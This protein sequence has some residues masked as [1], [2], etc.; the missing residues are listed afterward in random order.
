MVRKIDALADRAEFLR[1][2]LLEWG[3]EHS[4]RFP[5]RETTDPFQILVSEILLQ[6]TFAAKVAPVFVNLVSLCPTVQ[7]MARADPAD[8]RK[9][10]YPLGLL[11]RAETLVTM[12]RQILDDYEG[13]VPNTKKELLTIK[14][15]GEYVA[16]AVL[17]FAFGQAVAVVDTNV[18]R[19]YRRIFDT[20]MH[21]TQLKPDTITVELAEAIASKEDARNINWALLDFAALVCKHHRPECVGC[22]LLDVCTYGKRALAR[23]TADGT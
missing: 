22:P 14:G 7:D 20:S 4:R 17:C 2:T 11:Y 6:Q 19:V 8:I 5:W 12:A 3:A 1:K 13:M 15:V 9:L 23:T 18:L 10:I 21:T 16:S